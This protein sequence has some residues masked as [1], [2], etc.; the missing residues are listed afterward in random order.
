MSNNFVNP[1]KEFGS[2][3]IPISA[4]FPYNLNNLLNR[5]EIKLCNSKVE[6]GNKPSWIEWNNYSKH[7]S[8]FY[9][10]DEN[11]EVIKKYFQNS[12]LRNYDNVLMDFGYQIPLS[13]I[14][15]DIFINYWYE[16]VILAGYESVV[17]TEDGKLF[18]EFIRRSYYLKSNFQINP[19]S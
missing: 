5:F 8:F 12:V 9:D 11:E 19:N 2:S 1:F 17:I 4:D 10:F 6:L 14:P 3:I 13:K 7:Y 15:V 18:M 16:F